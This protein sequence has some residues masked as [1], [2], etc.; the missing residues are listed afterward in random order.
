MNALALASSSTRSKPESFF[1]S[2]ENILVLKRVFFSHYSLLTLE[3][4]KYFYPQPIFFCASRIFL[5]CNLTSFSLSI[6]SYV[7]RAPLIFRY[8]VNVHV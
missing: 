4:V 7:L 1:F 8:S 2:S 3:L 6:C 5:T